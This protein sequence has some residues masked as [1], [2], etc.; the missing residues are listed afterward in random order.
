MQNPKQFEI[1][2]QTTPAVTIVRHKGTYT[3]E[4]MCYIFH[5]PFRTSLQLSTKH[6]KL[7]Q[8]EIFISKFKKPL[9]TIQPHHIASSTTSPKKRPDHP[10]KSGSNI[11]IRHISSST[12]YVG[13]YTALIAIKPLYISYV[14]MQKHLTVTNLSQKFKPSC[15]SIDQP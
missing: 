7:F 8:R 5:T 12:M 13:V 3:S 2:T 1:R 14:V 10:C 6:F 15:K 9:A 4:D 11:D